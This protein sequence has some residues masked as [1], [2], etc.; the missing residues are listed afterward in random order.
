MCVCEINFPVEEVKVK[1]LHI[2]EKN[3]CDDCLVQILWL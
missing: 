2:F 1:N 3:V